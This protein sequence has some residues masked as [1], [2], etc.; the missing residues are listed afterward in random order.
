MDR[1]F[2]LVTQERNDGRLT[3]E[4]FIITKVCDFSSHHIYSIFFCFLYVRVLDSQA[5]ELDILYLAI[6]HVLST[7]L[8]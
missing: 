3:F 8:I 6:E 7:F 1:L 5:M 4:D 2:Q